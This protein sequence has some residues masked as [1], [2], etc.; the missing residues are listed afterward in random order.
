MLDLHKAH[1]EL[2]RKTIEDIERATALTWGG[3]AAAAFSI[4]QVEEEPQER[5]RWLWDGENYRQEALEHAAMVDD[6]AFLVELKRE[7]DQHRTQARRAIGGAGLA[8]PPAKGPRA[9]RAAARP[10]AV[11]Q[12]SRSAPRARNVGSA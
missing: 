10:R 4:A 3:R 1:A 11:G 7:I 6:T 9:R 5:L 12:G 8:G 2:R